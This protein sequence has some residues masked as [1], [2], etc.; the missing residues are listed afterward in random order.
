V[1]RH[2]PAVDYALP[3]TIECECE[4]PDAVAREALADTIEEKMMFAS[5]ELRLATD[6]EV[7]GWNWTTRSSE[8]LKGHPGDASS[9]LPVSWSVPVE[10]ASPGRSPGDWAHLE[11]GRTRLPT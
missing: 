4:D 7:E 1:G 3:N 6:L 10:P 9:C 2:E 5:D 11:P 8:I